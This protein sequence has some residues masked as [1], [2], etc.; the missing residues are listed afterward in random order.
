MVFQKKI[1][2]EK[3]EVDLSKTNLQNILKLC[4]PSEQFVLTEKY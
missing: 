4:L 2:V 3:G 1:N